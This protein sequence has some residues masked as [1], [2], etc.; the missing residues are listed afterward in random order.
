[1]AAMMEVVGAH[2][3][4]NPLARERVVFPLVGKVVSLCKIGDI[5][6]GERLLDHLPGGLQPSDQLGRLLLDGILRPPGSHLTGELC[7]SRAEDTMEPLNTPTNDM[8]C[9]LTPRAQVWRG[10]PGQL[11]TRKRGDGPHQADL[12][13]FPPFVQG[14][15][16]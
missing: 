7:A 11:F 10:P 13:I 2:A 5:P 12:V 16:R 6:A 8:T 9:D 1:L 3:P 14:H 15:K 4:D